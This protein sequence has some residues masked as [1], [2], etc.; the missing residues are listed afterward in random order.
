MLRTG[1]FTQVIAI[2]SSADIHLCETV[3]KLL[4]AAVTECFMQAIAV[5]TEKNLVHLQ[6]SNVMLTAFSFTAKQKLVCFQYL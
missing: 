3:S 4:V 6:K 1:Y 2:Y 5:R